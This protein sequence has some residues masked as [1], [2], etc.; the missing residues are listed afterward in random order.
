M[1]VRGMGFPI[2]IIGLQIEECTAVVRSATEWVESLRK[3]NALS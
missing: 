1:L 3:E 2:G